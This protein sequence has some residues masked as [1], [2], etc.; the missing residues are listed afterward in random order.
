MVSMEKLSV[1]NWPKLG[2]YKSPEIIVACK[3]YVNFL[4]INI[5]LAESHNKLAIC[6]AGTSSE[7]NTVVV[8]DCSKLHNFSTN[9]Q[10]KEFVGKWRNAADY[11]LRFIFIG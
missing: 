11:N 1:V 3:V 6:A 5:E 9:L 8:T 2:I 4:M 7:V 10:R